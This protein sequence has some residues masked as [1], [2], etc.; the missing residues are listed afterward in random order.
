[1]F[2]LVFFFDAFFFFF[3]FFFQKFLFFFFFF[4]IEQK[5]KT[6]PKFNPPPKKKIYNDLHHLSGLSLNAIT[7]NTVLLAC[8]RAHDPASADLVVSLMDAHGVEP[9]AAT[10]A[11]LS[12][13]R[14]AA[15]DVDGAMEALA[16]LSM[17]ER[18]GFADGNASRYS[19]RS[20]A[21]ELGELW[22][23]ITAIRA[24]IAAGIVPSRKDRCVWGVGD[25]HCA[26]G[27]VLADRFFLLFFCFM[28][29]TLIFY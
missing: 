4:F 12:R 19:A 9:N 5:S 26:E 14:A 29:H 11:A 10:F 28:V 13:V 23:G 27:I 7:F 17:T 15:G 25:T 3:F 16:G 1:L 8:Q 18:L 2:F 24:L 21:V 6:S 20:V 22:P